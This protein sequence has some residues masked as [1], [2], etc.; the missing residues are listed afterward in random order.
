M[1]TGSVAPNF[2]NPNGNRFFNDRDSR[3]LYK[4]FSQ[5][6]N[7]CLKD[8]KYLLKLEDEQ[9]NTFEP[10]RKTYPDMHRPF[11]AATILICCAI[12]A[13]S[14][15]RYGKQTGSVGKTF[16]NFVKEYFKKDITKSR[17]DYNA[18]YVYS[19]LRNALVH[20]YSLGKFLALGH[21]DEEKHLSKEDDRIVID[22]FMLYY[23]LEAVYK[24]YKKELQEGK[25]IEEFNRR[26]EYA[27]LVQ[28]F[29]KERIKK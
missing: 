9:G 1:V 22:V 18:N 19:G 24:K 21:E 11:V 10:D 27:P 13:L 25:F 29:P 14:A 26:W 17:K 20:G 4:F 23:D 16:E 28:Y 2:I 5:F 12:D 6:E 8:I 7:W 15:F 3:N